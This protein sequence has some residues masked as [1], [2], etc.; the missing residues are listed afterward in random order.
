MERE[1]VT[2]SDVHKIIGGHQITD[3]FGVVVDLQKSHGSRVYDSLHER[4]YVD[5]FTM[6]A[7]SPIGYNHPALNNEGFK[8]HLS[9]V[10]VNKPVL[11]DVFTVEYAE[12]VKVFTRIAGRPELPH[13]FWI[14]GGTLAVENALKASFDWKIRKNKASSAQNEVGTKVIHF[15]EAFHGRS[16]YTLSLTNTSAKVKHEWFPKFMDWP[17]VEN[18]KITFPL[19]GKNLEAVQ[20]AEARAAKQINEACEKHGDDIAAL[21]IEPIQGEGGDNHFRAEFFRELRGLANEHDFMLVL[22]EVQT[23]VGLTGKMWAFEHFGITPDIVVM[24]KKIQTSGI[25]VGKRIEEN[26]DNVFTISSRISSTWCGNLVDM[27]RATRY[28]QV[29]EEEKLVEN[30]AKIGGY[31]LKLLLEL[32]EKHSGKVFNARGLGLMTAFDALNAEERDALY[33]KIFENGVLAL[34][35]GEKTIRFRPPL[36]LTKEEADEAVQKIGDS[37]K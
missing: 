11:S 8:K 26:A 33:K 7:T 19:E 23:G 3:D 35:C 34:K 15:K 25:M 31:L 37:L 27:V 17:R 12:F 30:A 18:P 9:E 20:E 4:E 24:G 5:F 10:A 2:P 21:I 14:D 1:N 29:I 16:G 28:L 13:Y 36:N 6:F 32:Q 22:D